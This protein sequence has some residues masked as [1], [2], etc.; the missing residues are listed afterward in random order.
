MLKTYKYRIYPTKQQIELI[1]KH[2]GSCRFVYNLAL[3]TKQTAYAGNKINLNC[4]DLIKQ[5]PE[6]KKECEWLKEINSQSLQQAITH[7]DNAFTKFFKGQGD[8]PKFKKKTAKQSFN[9][10]QN[11]VVNFNT[12]KI[13]IPKFRKGINIVLHRNF[14]GTIKQATIIKTPTNKYF[15]SILVENNI[16]LPNKINIE[17]DNTTGIDL[18]IKSF[19][20]TSKGE[21]FENP[22]F[23]R[24]VQSRLKYIQSKY[25]KYKG[26]RTKHKLTILHEKIGNQRKDFLNK[27]STKL[28]GE[29][30]S[31]AIENLNINGMLQNHSLAQSII[32]V[33]W[34]MF[35]DM[36]KYKAEWQGKNII[37]IGRFESSS[38]TCNVCGTINKELELKDRVWTCKNC[39]TIHDRD[40]NAA[41]NIKNFALRNYVSGMDTQTQNELPTMVGVLTSEAHLFLTNKQFT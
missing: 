33:G 2:I 16:I 29:N 20:V 13:I 17:N 34:G 27:I 7:L 8:F 4:F 23:L 15:I 31:I 36:L 28:I 1:N 19:L 21:V 39:N 25:S 14:K 12:N 30:Q 22:K 40:I 3:E 6:L 35:I 26:K 5:L 24:I 38:K 11:I 18:G 32:D 9:I 37:Q 10:Q 41:I